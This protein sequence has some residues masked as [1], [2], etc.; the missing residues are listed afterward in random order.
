V[1]QAASSPPSGRVSDIDVHRARPEVGGVRGVLLA[2]DLSAA[3]LPATNEAL[4]IARREGA[5]LVVLSVVD[6]RVL[7][8]PGG[9]FGRRMDQERARVEAGVQGV[10]ERARSAGIRATFLVWEG[11]PADVILEAADAEDVD[12]IVMGSHGRGRLGRLLLGS[13]SAHVAAASP[14]RVLVVQS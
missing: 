7:R 14:R 10:V 1:Y 6:P 3:S 4:A 9:P 8:L 2:S 11:D 13:T 12:L 5:D